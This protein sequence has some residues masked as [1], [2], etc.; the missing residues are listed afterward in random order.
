MLKHAQLV[1]DIQ[2]NTRLC[3]KECVDCEDVCPLGLIKVTKTTY[4]GKPVKNIETLTPSQ[5]RHMQVNLE[6]QK[7]Y[8]P[9]CRVCE[10]NCASGALKVK[11]AIEGKI[12]IDQ[13]KCPE[14]C[15]DCI[16]VCPITGALT[17]G[18]DKKVYVNEVFC[19]YCGACKVVCP[20]PKALTLT[21]TKILHTPIRSGTWNKA[22]ERLTSPEAQVQEMKAVAAKK[23]K[24][25]VTRRFVL[26]E[27]IR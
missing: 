24:E 13:T 3:P 12:A 17:L 7:A 15:T 11:K 21:R 9:T 23:R 8:C 25:M 16:D 22:C 5:R 20:A 19:D 10:I 2:V 4:D 1:R 18:D 27:N 6:I 26:E 14:G